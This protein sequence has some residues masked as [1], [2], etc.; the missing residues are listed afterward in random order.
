MNFPY[1]PERKENLNSNSL[2]ELWPCGKVFCKRQ[3]P[4]RFAGSLFFYAGIEL[5][6][7]HLH[8]LRLI[9]SGLLPDGYVN[10]AF[11]HFLISDYYNIRHPFPAGFPDL[12]SY[13][14]V[15]V[16]NIDLKSSFFATS[17]AKAMCF[18]EIGTILT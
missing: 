3:F 10:R 15:A 17:S 1:L 5:F 16:I 14:Q 13:G 6:R 7:S 11:L 2:E 12:L 18:S 9:L 4:V 8:F